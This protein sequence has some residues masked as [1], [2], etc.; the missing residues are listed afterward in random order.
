MFRIFILELLVFLSFCLFWKIIEDIFLF[1]VWVN[2]KKVT[3]ISLNFILSKSCYLD[4]IAIFSPSFFI[5]FICLFKLYLDRFRLS[6][7]QTLTFLVCWLFSAVLSC[8]S[9]ILSEI[10]AIF[11]ILAWFFPLLARLGSTMLVTKLMVFLFAFI[12][13]WS[14]LKFE[15]IKI[16]LAK[17]TWAHLPFSILIRLLKSASLS[18][19]WAKSVK[20]WDAFEPIFI[21]WRNI[22]FMLLNWG[23]F[24]FKFGFKDE[25]LTL[26]IFWLFIN[27]FFNC[28]FVDLVDDFNHMVNIFH[29]FLLGLIVWY[30]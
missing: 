15:W 8:I 26:T 25:L 9:L 4:F 21:S 29:Y 18:E 27:W 13:S 6:I 3:W 17:A 23:W 10:I 20:F 14:I 7:S 24:F 1:G 12:Y 19:S 5:I 22:I 2:T 16:A 28:T 11:S 30:D